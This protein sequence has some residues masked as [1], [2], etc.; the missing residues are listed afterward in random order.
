MKRL[1]LTARHALSVESAT[2]IAL[3]LGAGLAL[4]SAT[5]VWPDTPDGLFHLHRVR[6]LAEALAAGVLLP[7]WFPTFAFGYGYPVF[8]FYAPAFYYPAALLHLAGLDTI[9]ATRLTLALLFALS[10][11][12]F[13]RLARLW[14]APPAALFAALLFALFPYRLYDLFVRGALP[15]FAAFFWLPLIMLAAARLCT[16]TGTTWRQDA[17]PLGLLALSW[18]GLI[19]THNLT[20]LMAAVTAASAAV[21]WLVW[22]LLTR[23]ARRAA[24]RLAFC[25]TGFVVGVLLSSWYTLP[26][27][28]ETTWV[29][30]GA[31]RASGYVS[32]FSQWST[33]L[34][35]TWA[36]PFPGADQ[37]TVPFSGYL[38]LTIVSGA[39]LLIARRGHWPQRPLLALTLLI[40][41]GALTLSTAGSAWLWRLG[42]PIMSRL[43]F[44]W[45]WQTI[46]APALALAAALIVDALTQNVARRWAVMLV[47]AVG[48][49]LALH[50]LSAVAW[51]P[52]PF[53]ADDLTDAYMWAF[54]AQHGQV[55]ATWTGEF[56]PRSVSEQRW[57]IGR[58]PANDAQTETAGLVKSDDLQMQ[59]LESS[60]LG[61]TYRLQQ[62]AGGRVV[63]HRFFYPA[64]SVRVDDTPV[65]TQPLGNLGLLSAVT[66]AGSHTLTLQWAPTR[67]QWLGRLLTALG[68]VSLLWLAWQL[69]SAS[70]LWALTP[71]CIVGVLALLAASGAT[72][73]TTPNQEVRADFGAVRLLGASASAT[74][75]GD[76]ATI[77]LHW[78][79]VKPEG[80]LTSFIHILGPDETIVAQHDGPLATEYTPASRWLPGQIIDTRHTLVLPD[81]L[82]AGAYR[83][84]I[85]LYPPQAPAQPITP[86]GRDTPFVVGGLLEVRP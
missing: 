74:R 21:A 71:W 29:G 6:A 30:I 4:Y 23:Q 57:A 25:V 15:E 43:Q 63:F 78:L 86:I 32:H 42:E 60:Y 2:A 17:P 47:C 48:V 11:L 19:V 5:A 52:A 53:S 80:D 59:L 1:R 50:T 56:L 37:A 39:G 34:A 83:L 46:V 8:N 14:T 73:R 36:A 67:A 77:D 38:A 72:M 24:A 40:V 84:R 33:L 9:S 28:L 75:P 16:A 27:L 62:A 70:R 26:A 55:G 31:E 81:K 22:A 3:C 45:R 85:G 76:E 68:W 58:A 41:V 54:D 18:A 64:W 82:A 7:R 10:T 79:I 35:W 13:Y 51:Q 12:A 66:P 65:T 49:L 20:A 61:A 44:P 69:K